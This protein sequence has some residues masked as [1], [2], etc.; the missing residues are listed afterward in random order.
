MIKGYESRVV[1]AGNITCLVYAAELRE[2]KTQSECC[3][4]LL[5]TE[6]AENKQKLMGIIS[7]D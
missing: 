1:E 4:A 5:K 3:S 6:Y 7:L 2:G